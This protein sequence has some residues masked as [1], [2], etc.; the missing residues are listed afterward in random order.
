L[1]LAFIINLNLALLL[2]GLLFFSDIAC[3]LDLLFHQIGLAILT[4]EGMPE[5]WKGSFS[6]SIFLFAR[7]NDTLFMGSLIF[8]IISAGHPTRK[9]LRAFPHYP[10][11]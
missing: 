8:S 4:S 9:N 3:I 11:V 7:L 10:V 6:Y 1:F 2:I 5:L